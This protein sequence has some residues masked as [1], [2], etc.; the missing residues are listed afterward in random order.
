MEFYGSNNI[1]I[2]APSRKNVISVKEDNR[3]KYKT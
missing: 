2:Q 1:R 3:M